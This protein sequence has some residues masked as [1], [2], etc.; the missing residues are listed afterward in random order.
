[1]RQAYPGEALRLYMLEA[2]TYARRGETQRAFEILSRALDAMPVQ[3]ELL[4][5]RALIA[6]QLGKLD[7]LESDLRKL[8]DQKPD[9]PA[10][11]NA[12]G[13]SLADHG[14][15][16]LDEAMGY[17]K[18]ALDQKP[19]DAAILDSYG[20]VLYRKGNLAESQNYLK[21]AFA[22]FHDP[23]IAAHLGE[24][25]WVNGQKAEARKVWAEGMK[26]NP[27]QDD[28]KRVREKYPEAFVSGRR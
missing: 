4:Y 3:P 28:M 15:D 6:E 13:F 8:L 7:I 11:L 19:N 25:L 20:W 21:K 1:M 12:L 22:N 16:R 14:T 27:D 17:I 9:D 26:I 18:K 10:A 5:S 24:V 23:E 2:E